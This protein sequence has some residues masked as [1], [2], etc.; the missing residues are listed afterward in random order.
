MPPLLATGEA[1]ALAL[2]A[3]CK[4]VRVHGRVMM[5][6]ILSAVKQVVGSR[7]QRHGFRTCAR[8][9]FNKIKS[10]LFVIFLSPPLMCATRVS[11]HTRVPVFQIVGASC[12]AAARHTP[13]HCRSG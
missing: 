2:A 10:S 11:V 8:G 9:L 1:A 6:F 13:S 12:M 4:R 7:R 3:A 5:V